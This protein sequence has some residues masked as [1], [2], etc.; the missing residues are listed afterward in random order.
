[1]RFRTHLLLVA[2][3]GLAAAATHAEQTPYQSRLEAI[4]GALVDTAL[5]APTRVR[6]TAWVDESGTLRENAHITSDVKVRGVRVSSYLEPELAPETKVVVDAVT[7]L[8]RADGCTPAAPRYKR[9]ALVHT[10]LQPAGRVVS[11]IW[12][13]SRCTRSRPCSMN[14]PPR[15]RGPYD[16]PCGSTPNTNAA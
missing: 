13:I 3:T 4:Q 12:V 16:P 2:L 8:V 7:P 6:A 10:L 9:V 11:R 1:M 14:S 15:W 5:L